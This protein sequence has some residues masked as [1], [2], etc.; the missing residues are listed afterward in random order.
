MLHF[1]ILTLTNVSH[2][3]EKKTETAYLLCI[4]GNAALQKA[5]LHQIPRKFCICWCVLS[6]ESFSVVA[7]LEGELKLTPLF[8]NEREKPLDICTG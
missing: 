7:P 4:W 6:R 8:I 2:A 5:L 1:L 3:L